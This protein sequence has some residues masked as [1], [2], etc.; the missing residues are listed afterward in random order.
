MRIQQLK[1]RAGVDF[2]HGAFYLPGTAPG[3][4][5]AR[6]ET[7]GCAVLSVYA[8]PAPDMTVK[9]TRFGTIEEAHAYLLATPTGSVWE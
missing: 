3:E 5:S 6:I 9:P 7:Q 1:R 8:R 4:W 2:R